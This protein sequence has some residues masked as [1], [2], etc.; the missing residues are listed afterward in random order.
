MI[1]VSKTFG[2]SSILSSP[3]KPRNLEKTRFRGIFLR[4]KSF[5]EVPKYVII[6]CDF[7]YSIVRVLYSIFFLAKKYE[8]IKDKANI[9]NKSNKSLY[10]TRRTFKYK[11]MKKFFLRPILYFGYIIQ[12]GS[13][14]SFSFILTLLII[15][16]HRIIL[17]LS[18]KNIYFAQLFEE[19]IGLDKMKKRIKALLFI[20]I[21]SNLSCLFY[22]NNFFNYISNGKKLIYIALTQNI[23]FIIRKLVTYNSLPTW[24]YFKDKIDFTYLRKFGIREKK[25]NNNILGKSEK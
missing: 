17:S 20:G 10:Y 6:I 11:S 8:K 24:F 9:T 19:S 4:S 2:G 21:I 5:S 15:I 14:A 25:I 22:T 7:I 1:G 3:V 16:N 12:F 13:V 23:I 18:L